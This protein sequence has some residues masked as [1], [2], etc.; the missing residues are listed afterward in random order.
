[1]KKIF[2]I[3]AMIFATLCTVIM[4]TV[5][6]V[7]VQLPSQFSV[8]E[9]ETLELEKPVPVKAVKINKSDKVASNISVGKSYDVSLKI[10]GLIPVKNIRVNVVEQTRLVPC[11]IPFGIRMYT[12]GVMVVGLSNFE[13]DEGLQN[14]AQAAGIR[15]GDIII[16]INGSRVNSNEEIA[17]FVENS[18]GKSLDFY[19]KRKDIYFTGTV[20][21]KL[22][23]AEQ[24]YRVGLWVR[25]S[26]AGIGTMTFYND[27]GIFAGLGHGVCDVDTGEIIPLLS[28]D[29]VN[30]SI[31]GILKG[32]SGT[33]GELR[34]RFKDEG[35]LGALIKNTETG[36][37]GTLYQRP[38]N[39]EAIPIG[40]KQQVKEGPAQIIT[41][42]DDNQRKYYD[43]EI[44]RVNYNVNSPTKNMVIKVT[45]PIL[46]EKTGGIVQGMSGSP[47]I[48]NGM[49]VG[50]VTHVF[51]NDPTRGY[52][53]FAENMQKTAMNEIVNNNA[54]AA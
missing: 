13:T 52:G 50:A 48:Q 4:V 20:T 53:I 44:E 46:I 5:V 8:F 30:V 51:I 19:I 2:Q 28:G 21:P 35:E 42:L 7:E 34:G 24:R 45:D 22:S 41:T 12:E 31:V 23:T 15:V 54:A 26:S 33:P 36:V 40:L 38:L 17:S 16:S 43:I 11:G 47:I 37:Y 3:I 27:D 6:F 1:M 32:K 25:D 49:I 29:I 18:Q 9:G 14:P 10:F 39:E